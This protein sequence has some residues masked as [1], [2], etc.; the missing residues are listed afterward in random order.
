[1]FFDDS[2]DAPP[3]EIDGTLESW[4]LVRAIRES[5]AAKGEAEE[6]ERI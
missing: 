6:E 1:M 3:N 5:V 4:T 2:K